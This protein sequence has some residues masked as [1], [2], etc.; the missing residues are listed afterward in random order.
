MPGSSVARTPG[1]SV[2]FGG[3]VPRTGVPR[4]VAVAFG[5]AEDVGVVE[6]SATSSAAGGCSGASAFFG[7]ASTNSYDPTKTT[8]ARSDAPA[9]RPVARSIA[10]FF[11]E[12]ELL[13]TDSG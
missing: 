13:M 9:R 6:R 8:A 1:W 12:V 3:G 10:Y 2:I 5:A 11:A 4:G 7:C